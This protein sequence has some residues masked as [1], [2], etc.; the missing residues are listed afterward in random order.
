MIDKLFLLFR[1]KWK[2]FK[3][4]MQQVPIVYVLLLL[5]LSALGVNVLVKL[6]VPVTWQS[7]AGAGVIQL[8]IF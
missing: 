8:F 6:A 1:L 5:F 4:S 2:I 3:R 7:M